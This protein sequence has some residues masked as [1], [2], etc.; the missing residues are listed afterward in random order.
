M[1]RAL[2]MTHGDIGLELVRVVK[3]IIGPVDGLTA[4]SNAGL[5]GPDLQAQVAGWLDDGDGD[6]GGELIFIDDYGGSCASAALIACG[7]DGCRAVIS[8][9]N[10]AMLLGYV[11]WRENTD[12]RELAAKLVQKGREAITLV[13]GR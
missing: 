6:G 4:M 3:M 11:T 9:V 2:V 13:G 5:S 12:N 8:G 7:G 10:L 1:I